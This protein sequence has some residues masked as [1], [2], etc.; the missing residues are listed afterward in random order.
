LTGLLATKTVNP[1]GSDGWFYGN[2]E[3]FF[4]QLKLVTI[5]VSYSFIVS[6]GIFKFINLLQ[7]MRVSS[8]EEEEGLDST[9]HNEKYSQGT[10]LVSNHGFVYEKDVEDD[11]EDDMEN[12]RH[13]VTEQIKLKSS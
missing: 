12:V 9:Q 11:L 2:H 1:A 6:Y 5:T 4:T 3:F 7:P 13:I 8:E 10:L